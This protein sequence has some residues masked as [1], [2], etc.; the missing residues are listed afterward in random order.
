M[1]P[2]LFTACLVVTA[3]SSSADAA[4]SVT[5][6]FAGAPGD[7]I[8]TSGIATG[9]ALNPPGLFSRGP[10]LTQ[11]TGA[12][13]MNSR[14]WTTGGFDF[15]A[16]F[17]SFL[18][19]FDRTTPFTLGALTFNDQRS[20]TGPTQAVIR[21]S[22]D[23]YTS[24]V[25]SWSPSETNT[26]RSFTFTDPFYANLN[27][28]GIDVRIYAFSAGGATGTY[29]ISNSL[30]LSSLDPSPVAATPA[31]PTVLAALAVLPVL[32]LARRRVAA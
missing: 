2:H 16:D 32:V 1:R 7:Q 19:T 24:N 8:S 20:G 11:N 31:P 12:N 17:Y 18:V 10:G 29:R 27:P 30:T 6:S 13:S 15:N 28:A 3:F 14:G 26:L 23:S 25:F 4:F 9:T 5:Y 21:T 22:L